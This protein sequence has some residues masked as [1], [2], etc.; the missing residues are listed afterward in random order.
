ML[1][2]R[3]NKILDLLDERGSL[4]LKELMKHCNVSEAT[5]RRDLTNLEDK[6]LL[7]RTHGGAMK[8]S[9]ARGSEESVEAKRADFLQEKRAVAKYLWGRRFILMPGHRH[10]K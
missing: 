5:R 8:R 1:N 6:N 10:M 9:A 4:N 2:E 7:Y 3:W